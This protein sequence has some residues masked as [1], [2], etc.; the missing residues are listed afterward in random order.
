MSSDPFS[1]WR[2][3]WLEAHD[4]GVT[5]MMRAF[6]MQRTMLKGDWAGEPEERRAASEN[7]VA[8]QQELAAA[9]AA[10]L[11]AMATP[12]AG[13]AVTP[14]KKKA[15]SGAKRPK[16]PAKKRAPAKKVKASKRRK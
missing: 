6:E 16:L 5:I 13:V 3:A 8:A 14:V 15:A 2:R 10:S 9:A 7:S 11:R 12:K 1:D 4:A